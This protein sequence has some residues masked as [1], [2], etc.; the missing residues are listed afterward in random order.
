M[1]TLI[2]AAKETRAVPIIIKSITTMFATYRP[3]VEHS[4]LFVKT[5]NILKDKNFLVAPKF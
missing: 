1:T 2:M 5:M 3:K 4:I